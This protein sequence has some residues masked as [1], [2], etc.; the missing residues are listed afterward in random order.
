MNTVS[1][2]QGNHTSLEFAKVYAQLK[3]PLERRVPV[4]VA[5]PLVG[6]QPSICLSTCQNLLLHTSHALRVTLKAAE[7]GA[8]AYLGGKLG[9]G[10]AGE[11]WLEPSLRSRAGP[12]VHGPISPDSSKA[13]LCQLQGIEK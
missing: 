11:G 3:G 2:A 7:P 9:V 12:S 8:F 1:R 5:W 4:L 13:R 6:E 10:G